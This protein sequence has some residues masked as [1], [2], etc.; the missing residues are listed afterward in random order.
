MGWALLVREGRETHRKTVDWM[1][2]KKQNTQPTLLIFTILNG[3]FFRSKIV[4]L[5]L[6]P[7]H[8]QQNKPPYGC[9]R[10]KW[11]LVVFPAVFSLS[12]RRSATPATQQSFETMQ[13]IRENSVSGW[14]VR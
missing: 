8:A 1:C 9:G 6:N 5:L 10:A 2:S 7:L 4:W 12:F 13:I 14:G 11:S 3:F